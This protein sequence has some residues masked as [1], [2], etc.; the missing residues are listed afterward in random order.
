MKKILVTGG[1]VFVSKFVA[2]YFSK[3]ENCEVY[4]LNRNTKPQVQGVHVIETDRHNLGNKLKEYHFDTVIDVCAYN[5]DD[6][7]DLFNALNPVENYIFISS[8]AV[9]PETNPQPFTEEQEV[10]R[11]A[12]WGDYGTNKIAAEQALLDRKKDAYIL[13]PPY[14]YGPMQNIYREPFAFEC[15]LAGRKFYIPKDGTMKMQFFH[16][17]DLCRVIEKILETR[18]EHHIFNVGNKDIVDINEYISLCYR[19]AGKKLEA[20]HVYNHDNPRDYFNFHDYEYI[21]DVTRQKELITDTKDLETGLR[22]SFEWYVE[23][24]EEVNRKEYIKFI[25]ELMN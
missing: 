8:S 21:L 16:V 14:L 17:E 9:Y 6:V 5:Q 18:P 25:D 3:K 10:G 24:K 11:N 13:R 1:T 19:V 12:V 20:V 7:N 4:V 2:R 23:H 22:E 15:A